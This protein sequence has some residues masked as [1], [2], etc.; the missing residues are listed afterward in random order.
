MESWALDDQPFGRCGITC[1]PRAH[2]VAE[3]TTCHVLAV[4]FGRL[5]AERG[6][7]AESIGGHI[8]N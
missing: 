5:L 4:I 6:N 1:H 8:R 3:R 7:P 2:P